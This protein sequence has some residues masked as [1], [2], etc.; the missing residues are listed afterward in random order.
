MPFGL[1][2]AA[3]AV[4][5]VLVKTI[6]KALVRRPRP[7]VAWHLVHESGWSFPSGHA[8]TSFAVYGLLFVLCLEQ[9][10]S[11]RKRWLLCVVS[12]VLAFAIGLSRIYLGVHYLS[13]V[14]AG[15]SFGLAT[16]AGILLLREHLRRK[17]YLQ[18][19]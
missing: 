12:G 13:D 1:P 3:A 9:V 19:S 10:G 17:G 18:A 14:L 8:I 16:I 5:T 2:V 15:W 11:V 7:E 4:V 6:V